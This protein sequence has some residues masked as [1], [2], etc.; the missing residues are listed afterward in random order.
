MNGPLAIAIPYYS[1][2]DLLRRA[3][4]S[5]VRQSSSEWA[6]LVC[7]DGPDPSIRELVASYAD[8]RIRYERNEQNLGMAGNWNRCLTR[9]DGEW[10]TLLH[11]DDELLPDYVSTMRAAAKQFPGAAALYCKAR[12]I[13][14]DGQPVFSAVD[15]VKRFI[16]PR[17]RGPLV[18]SGESAVT[19]LMHG[20]FIVCPTV[21]YRRD[22]LPNEPF[23]ARWKMVLDLDLFCR[24]LFS[25]ETI[26]GLPVTAYAYRRHANNATVALTE[27]LRRFE[28]EASLHDEVSRRARD[29]GWRRAA[30]VAS[31]KR[32]IRVH[33]LVRW[34]I[35]VC[36]GNR[37]GAV[38]KWQ[39][40]KR[41]R[42]T[43]H[44]ALPG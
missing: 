21:C 28:E 10:A 43:G 42:S 25:G 15:Y 6:L 32:V 14:A 11:A 22:R 16:E 29:V 30:Q 20:D 27:S 1:G 17:S 36:R 3:I 26:V 8:P 5:V 4:A 13:D 7:D 41:L 39:L 35:D 44:G 38:R 12:V 23:N 19:A 18:L 9:V 34:A 2:P 31:A 33:L 24:M 37:A 40:W